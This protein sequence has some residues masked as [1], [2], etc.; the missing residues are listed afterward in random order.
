MF[1]PRQCRNKICTILLPILLLMP[2]Y[3]TPVAIAKS[4]VPIQDL[5][6]ATT[7]YVVL[8][9]LLIT[10]SRLQ[11]NIITDRLD[12]GNIDR[13]MVDAL[14]LALDEAKHYQ[15]FTVG[16]NDAKLVIASPLNAN[17]GNLKE[18]SELLGVRI[19]DLGVLA[20]RLANLG[21]VVLKTDCPNL[22]LINNSTIPTEQ[23]NFLVYYVIMVQNLCKR[24]VDWKHSGIDQDNATLYSTFISDDGPIDRDH[25]WPSLHRFLSTPINQTYPITGNIFLA[26]YFQYLE[27]SARSRFVTFVLNEFVVPSRQLKR[28]IPELVI[29]Q[30]QLN[31]GLGKGYFE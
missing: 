21:H 20:T 5:P 8:R 28:S 18:L 24:S 7:K 23:H 22:R 19:A 1:A 13:E 27:L 31:F 11:Q 14:A 12:A 6:H 16:S 17:R 4:L 9:H 2:L 25:L 3:D 10:L 15:K 26:M 30:D 29:L